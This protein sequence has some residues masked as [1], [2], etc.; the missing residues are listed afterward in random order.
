MVAYMN[1]ESFRHNTESGNDDLLQPQP[2][3]A[4]V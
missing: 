1:E 2:S 3:G 4:V